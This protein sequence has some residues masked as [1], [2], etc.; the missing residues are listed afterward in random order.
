MRF[1][2][3]HCSMKW[4]T[5]WKQRSCAMSHVCLL[6]YCTRMLVRGVYWP[7]F[8]SMRTRRRHQVESLWRF[9][10]RSLPSTWAFRNWTLVSRIRKSC[11]FVLFSVCR[12][13]HHSHVAIDVA[14]AVLAQ[15]SCCTLFCS[16]PPA[17]GSCIVSGHYFQEVSVRLTTSC[18]M[19]FQLWQSPQSCV[20][21]RLLFLSPAAGFSRPTSKVCCLVIIPSTLDSAST[22]SHPLD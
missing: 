20:H 4:F 6:G 2:S 21:I 7:A 16:Q 8:T 22:S 10:F 11:F 14:V 1:S 5:A 12:C 9:S 19:I 13:G 18:L 15:N 3:I 17:L